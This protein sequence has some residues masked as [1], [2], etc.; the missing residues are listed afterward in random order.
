[1]KNVILK[2]EIGSFLGTALHAGTSF[3]VGK[4]DFLNLYPLN[5]KIS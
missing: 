5:F 4:V 1:M 2:T 3:P